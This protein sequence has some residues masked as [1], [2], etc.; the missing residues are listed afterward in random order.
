M[1]YIIYIIQS[2]KVKTFVNI[3]CIANFINYG[4]LRN[5]LIMLNNLKT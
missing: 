4:A 1:N 2:N 5:Y 3:F